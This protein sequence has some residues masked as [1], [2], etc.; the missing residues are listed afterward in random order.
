[1]LVAGGAAAAGVGA[2]CAGGGVSVVCERVRVSV[3]V[4]G[5]VCGAWGDFNIGDCG[6][7][8]VFG[9]GVS[10]GVQGDID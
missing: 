4:C 2:S 5:A 8:A 9:G 10:A 1:M 7:D 6:I 3:F